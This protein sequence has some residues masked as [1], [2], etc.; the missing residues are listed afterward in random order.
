MHFDTAAALKC[1]NKSYSNKHTKACFVSNRVWKINT[2]QFQ[3]QRKLDIR[4]ELNTILN[5]V[6]AF[7]EGW[8]QIDNECK[9]ELK[10]K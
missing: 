7:Q 1:K 4:S 3:V 8:Q 9:P 6:A 2:I 5:L 10:I